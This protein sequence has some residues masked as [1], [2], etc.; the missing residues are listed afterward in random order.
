MIGVR[1]G[2]LPS[3]LVPSSL[4]LTVSPDGG[5]ADDLGSAQQVAQYYNGRTYFAYLNG[6]SGDVCVR[7]Y[8]HATGTVSAETTL[9]VGLSTDTAHASPV[10]LVRE[11]DHRIVVAY[12]SEASPS[13]RCRVSTN[14]EDIA[15]FG[16]EIDINDEAGLGASEYTYPHIIQLN[17]ESGAPIYLFVETYVDGTTQTWGY[18]R[19]DGTSWSRLVEFFQEPAQYGYLAFSK[20]SETRVDILATNK[21]HSATPPGKLYHC[22]FEGGNFYRT[23]GQM[24][25]S[26]FPFSTASMT[27]VFD[28]TAASS[29][30]Q[31]R[32]VMFAS[33]GSPRALFREYRGAGDH[34]WRWGS[35]NGESWTTVEVCNN[36][37]DADDGRLTVAAGACMDPDDPATLYISRNVGGTNQMFRFDSTDTGTSWRVLKMTDG[38]SGSVRPVP[39]H[40]ANGLRVLWLNGDSDPNPLFA[41]GIR[42]R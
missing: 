33:D 25:T 35:W 17:D 4:S 29:T 31:G 42:G 16:A 28:G 12:T 18:T 19:F 5:W 34:R 6:Q 14:P 13:L 8:D 7:Y 9:M 36:G 24:I 38:A 20:T 32:Q 26:L 2:R 30:V 11:P 15:T 3:A 37:W 21:A 27:E 40:G 22:Y 39:V 23:N 41:C 10:L 1:F